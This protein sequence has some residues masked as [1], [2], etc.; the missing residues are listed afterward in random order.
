MNKILYLYAYFKVRSHGFQK[1][2]KGFLITD[3]CT[4]SAAHELFAK[5]YLE[6]ERTLSKS[7]DDLQSNKILKPIANK[8]YN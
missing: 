3:I 4:I 5:V 2:F 6:Y 8:C 7:I 1:L